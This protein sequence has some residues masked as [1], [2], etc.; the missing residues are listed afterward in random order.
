M[1]SFVLSLLFLAS[2]GN[3]TLIAKHDVDDDSD[4]YNVNVDCDDAHATVN[5]DAEEVVADGVDQNCDGQ[6]LCYVD[7]DG[8][9]FGDS[10]TV[11]ADDCD[12]EGVADNADDC[13]D[14]D[15]AF[16]PGAPESCDV[17]IDYNCDGSVEYA[18]ADADD[19]P[20]CRD[21]DD[22]DASA[23]PGAAEITAD[24]IDQDCD[25]VDVC[26]VDSDGDKAGSEETVT[27][28]SLTCDGEGESI[29]NDDCDD[30]NPDAYPGAPELV[31]DGTDEDCD[32]EEVCFVDA[33]HDFYGSLG[34]A[35]F[36]AL[37]C[38]D[39][40]ASA[41]SLDCDDAVAS[42]NPAA[43][44]V[45]TDGIDQD[46]DGN[47]I[48]F[49]DN[50]HDEYGATTTTVGIGLDCDQSAAGLANDDD[51]CDDGDAGANPAAAETIAD[52][53]DQDCDTNDTCYV[54]GDSDGYGDVATAIAVGLVCDDAGAHVAD[55]SDDCDDSDPDAYP[56]AV[57]W[58]A[59]G[60]DQDCDGGDTC[61]EDSDHDG[62]GSSAL[63]LSGSL[64]CDVTLLG[65]A[66][67]DDD[68]DD[69]T[70]SIS[71]VGT[72]LVADGI[73]QDCDGGDVCYVDG[74]LDG[75]GS[76]DTQLSADLDCADAGEGDDS[77]DCL[78]VGTSAAETWPGAAPLDSAIECM[79]DADGDGYGADSPAAG[80]TAG[81]DC[82]DADGST[83]SCGS[84][85]IGNDVEFGTAS[86][87]L[88]NY[89]LGS[90]ITVPTAMTVTDLALIGKT[91]VGNVKMALYS[92]VAGSPS[93]LLVQTAGTA[94]TVGV[95]EI[96][97]TPT[98]IAAGNYW[99]MAVYN[100]DASIGISYAGTTTVK[101]RSLTYASALPNPFGA[102]TTY[103][104]Q[105]FN[106]Y[107]VGY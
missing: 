107:I 57:E 56:G 49:V 66:D 28:S 63:V 105:E 59:D 51:D 41:N 16:H 20:A 85:H 52:G 21:C 25:G 87:H 37:D 101:Y 7:A 94:V 81:T 1:R 30:T 12:G 47:D 65:I 45:T 68:C 5:P 99:I 55:D 50:D 31:A 91:A 29:T 96:S 40:G 27:G 64:N 78:D 33:D 22:G 24:G 84:I 103:S 100:V 86:H 18:D 44:E 62:Y 39:I 72:E 14:A 77:D 104:G 10:D 60:T 76:T 90:K 73:D 82:D 17:P 70:V 35:Q 19:W 83:I 89:L 93:A 43:L 106:Y 102:I 80:V 9:S 71:P 4:G 48:C 88:P 75:Y 58:V 67:N 11:A 8:D 26:F 53:V 79:T 61:Y 34:V 38:S 92:D 2:C 42:V 98:A 6:D 69:T 13:D 36:G 54:D 97:V 23:Y 3:D 32:G 15:A 46:C 95:E 74:D